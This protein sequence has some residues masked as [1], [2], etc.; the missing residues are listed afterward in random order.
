MFNRSVASTTNKK[1]DDISAFLLTDSL[2]RAAALD[3]TYNAGLEGCQDCT[4][5]GVLDEID[6]W[7]AG[8]ETKTIFWLEGMAGTGKTTVSRSVCQR[9]KN[10]GILGASFFFKR[11]GGDLGTLDMFVTTIAYQLVS[12][13]PSIAQYIQKVIAEKPDILHKNQG[14][15]KQFDE[16]ILQPLQS[17]HGSGQ[18]SRVTV[19]V[20]DALDECI[21]IEGK[22]NE[23][24]R[25]FTKTRIEQGTLLKFFITA[26]PDRRIQS[27]FNSIRNDV[28]LLALE[29]IPQ[30]VVTSDI[31]LF[32]K[33]KLGRIGVD[34]GLAIDWPG[35]SRVDQ[36]VKMADRLFIFATTMCLF[37]EDDALG[38][39]E[40]NLQVV[41]GSLTK[42]QG[43]RMDATY[44]P[45]LDQLLYQRTPN[46]MMPRS[47]NEKET[48]TRKFLLVVGS[49]IL[50]SKPLS[51][52][53]LAAILG[54]PL[55]TVKVPL[56]SLHSVLKIPSDDDL[57]I[58]LLHLSFRDFLVDEEKGEK[59]PF[60]VDERKNHERL[61]KRCLSVLLE[62]DY[63]RKDICRLKKPGTMREEVS[64]ETV[65]KYLPKHVQYACLYWVHHMKEGNTKI[66]D[67]HQA[68]LFLRTHFLHWLEAL[69]LLGKTFDSISM[70]SHLINLVGVSHFQPTPN[71]NTFNWLTGY[72]VNRSLLAPGS[73]AF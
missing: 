11:D 20:I 44:G 35:S 57:P 1:I 33:T 17:S 10:N 3:A 31:K 2:S 48:I 15:K 14:V 34:N 37:I 16:L 62:G 69:S 9:L 7:V 55:S 73:G 50:L 18:N 21:D 8:R 5:V 58:E 66:R 54:I 39:P 53:S 27:A 72:F 59:Y 6:T 49:I 36:L 42:F 41:L 12:N 46:G 47:G 28:H 24:L 67:N 13:R 45:I 51:A 23:L 32:L 71:F 65:E 68:Y 38:N 30:K 43:S 40:S 52:I 61:A 19:I 26:R 64:S 4:R 63:L 25:L 70:I 60:W 56:A 29:N 22:R